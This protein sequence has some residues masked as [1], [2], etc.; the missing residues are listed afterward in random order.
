MARD[1][2]RG[3]DAGVPA[4][5]AL[6]EKIKARGIPLA[7]EVLRWMVTGKG[8][9]T[10]SPSLVAASGMALAF[11]AARVALRNA[12]ASKEEWDRKMAEFA[13]EN[14]MFTVHAVGN[15]VPLEEVVDKYGAARVLLGGAVLYIIGLVLMS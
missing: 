8:M 13:I 2:R 10:Y 9:L 12:H 4:W 14:L 3:Q 1:I 5:D 11:I 15:F 6:V 7:M